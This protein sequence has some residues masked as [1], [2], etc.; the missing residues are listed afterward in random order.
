MQPL[1]TELIANS[2]A[3]SVTTVS[4]EPFMRLIRISCVGANFAPRLL[5]AFRCDAPAIA[6]DI[7][8]FLYLRSLRLRPWIAP[9]Y[10][11]WPGARSPRR[12]SITRKRRIAAGKRG[13]IAA[14]RRH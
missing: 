5:Y 8:A 6:L 14:I 12:S 1:H 7:D 3:A 4:R 9:A 11:S 10:R 2:A 13:T